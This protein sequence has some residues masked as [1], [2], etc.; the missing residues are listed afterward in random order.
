[1]TEIKWDLLCRYVEKI[2]R[3]LEEPYG[4]SEV[5]DKL[6]TMAHVDVGLEVVEAALVGGEDPR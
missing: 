1:M 5:K 3:T 6:M 2:E 4:A